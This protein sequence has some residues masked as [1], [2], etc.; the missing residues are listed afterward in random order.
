MPR[1]QTDAKPPRASLVHFLNYLARMGQEEEAKEAGPTGCRQSSWDEFLKYSRAE[2]EIQV[3]NYVEE[4]SGGTKLQNIIEGSKE[5]AP[6]RERT[7]QEGW[8][9]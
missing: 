4:E 3:I 2:G 7:R 6:C 5:D 1:A 8:D 9:L